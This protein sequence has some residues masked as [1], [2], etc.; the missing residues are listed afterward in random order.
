[1]QC[2]NCRANLQESAELV[3]RQVSCPSCGITF[4]MPPPMNSPDEFAG[5][6]SPPGTFDTIA[7]AARRD[8]SHATRRRF[9]PSTSA[10]DLFDWK[11]ERYVTPWVVRVT[12][13][14]ILALSTIWLLLL[15]VGLLFAMLPEGSNVATPNTGNTFQQPRMSGYEFS[16]P[17][18]VDNS[19]QYLLRNA[20][21]VFGFITAIIGL[22][23]FLLWVRVVLESLIV[24]FNIAESLT[25]IDSRISKAARPAE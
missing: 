4:V 24:L 21:A 14:A 19:R 17:A 1:M 22:M 20:V 16:P 25:S 13:I 12:W 7:A 2:P 9:K 6:S 15:L 11:F 3:G 23:I 18:A 10:L 8:F 5:P